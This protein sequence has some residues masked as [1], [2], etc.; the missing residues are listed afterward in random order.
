MLDIRE[1]STVLAALRFYQ[2]AMDEAGH[3]QGIPSD[4][5]DIADNLGQVEPLD[6]DEIDTLCEKL[7]FGDD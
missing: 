2:A 5:V 7:N 4:I 6:A 1:L 3:G